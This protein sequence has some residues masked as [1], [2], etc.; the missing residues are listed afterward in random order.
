M[1][2]DRSRVPRLRARGKNVEQDRRDVSGYF[3]TLH[4][5]ESRSAPPGPVLGKP[6]GSSPM[7]CEES[8]AQPPPLYR[9]IRPRSA[10]ICAIPT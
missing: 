4:I 2:Y 3:P 1:V 5:F 10:P 8:E 9:L 7:R 6:D